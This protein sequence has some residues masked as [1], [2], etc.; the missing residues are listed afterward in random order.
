MEFYRLV[1]SAPECKVNTQA[2]GPFKIPGAW[3]RLRN[4]S[5]YTETRARRPPSPPDTGSVFFSPPPSALHLYMLPVQSHGGTGLCPGPWAAAGLWGTCMPS[6]GV[7]VP[8]YP[9]SVWS[10]APASA[11][12][13][14]LGDCPCLLHVRNRDLACALCVCVC[15]VGM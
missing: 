7:K 10:W 13:F 8:T 14:L 11:C 15:C 9:F 4:D 12:A 2:L 5:S 6:A 1:A 3:P